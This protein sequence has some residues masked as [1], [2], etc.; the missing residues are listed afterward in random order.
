MIVIVIGMLN[1]GCMI[2][3]EDYLRAAEKYMKKKY[4]E[5]FEG[6][7]FYGSNNDSMYVIPKKN[8]NWYVTVRFDKPNFLNVKFHD[9]YFAFLVK[10]ELEDKVKKEVESIYGKSKVFCNPLGFSLPDD[11]NKSTQFEEYQNRKICNLEIYVSGNPANRENELLKFKE[12]YYSLKINF[13]M[14]HIIYVSED[15]LDGLDQNMAEQL[16]SND[17]YYWKVFVSWNIENQTDEVV[18]W[19]QGNINKS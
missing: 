18:Y 3:Q 5:E 9:N 19:Y 11:W 17:E 1:C 12:S 14:I 7:Y 16:F 6:K 13:A 2:T 15:I 4:G 10:E 8:P